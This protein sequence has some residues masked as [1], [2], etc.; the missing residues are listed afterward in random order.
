[1]LCCSETPGAPQWARI[2]SMGQ[3]RV[4]LWHL[5]FTVT[6]FEIKGHSQHHHRG[7][8]MLLRVRYRGSR[9]DLHCARGLT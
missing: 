1:M 8:Q 5:A 6:F 2:A 9:Q 4:F 3:V 7:E